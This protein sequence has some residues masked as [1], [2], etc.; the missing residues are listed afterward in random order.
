VGVPVVD[1][2]TVG[3][4]GGS[5]AW[6]DD[7]G[8]LRVGPR[9]AGADPG[10]V[11]YGEGSE[12]TVTD[13]N[14]L[15]GRMSAAHFLGGA[16]KLDVDRAN[17]HMLTFANDLGMPVDEAAEG[18]L[19]VANATMERAIRVISVE[20]GH[21]PR[22]FALVAFGGAGPMH[23]CDLAS[24]MS[25]PNVIVPRN[26]GVLS[27][28]GLLLADV[29]KDFSQTVLLAAEGLSPEKLDSLFAP[30]QERAVGILRDEGFALERI[31]LERL[32]DMRYVG[33]SYE[34]TVVATGDFAKAFHDEHFKLY[35]HSNES[36]PVEVVN[37]RLAAKGS[38]DPPRFARRE[39]TGE[40]AGDAILERKTAVFDGK[41]VE[42]P[43][44]DR[45]ALRP[46][47]KF[48]GPAIV[49]ETSAT[50][51]VAPDFEASVDGYDNLILSCAAD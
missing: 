39:E 36:R 5:I 2:H 14:L 8:S 50:T 1:I 18:V 3:A 13:A 46:G 47:N 30:M 37:I 12:I 10:P 51:V 44:Y 41:S 29:A 4:G 9:S 11:C 27:A 17:D 21:D 49:V 35:G 23:A 42:T 24:G 20:R 25:I 16:M 45:S 31:G 40:D 48:A 6:L 15:L 38:V 28:L 19:R 26:A 33:Q 22:R 43:V 7:A 32:L 34:V